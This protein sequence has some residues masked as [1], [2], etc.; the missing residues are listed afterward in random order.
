MTRNKFVVVIAT[1][2]LVVI[3]ACILTGSPAVVSES[4]Q[5]S[6]AAIQTEIAGIVASTEAAQTSLA[7][8]VLATLGSIVTDTP[9]FTFTPSLTFTPSPS[10]TLTI[11]Q[12][13]SVPMVSVS[14]ET[15]C[16]SG[17][18]DPYAILGTLPAGVK[19]EVVARTDY[20]DWIIKL[21]SNPAITCWLWGQYATIT[22]DTTT[23]PKVTPV[24]SPTPAASFQVEYEYTCNSGVG[25]AV[26]FRVTNNGSVTW[27]SNRVSATDQVTAATF[28]DN[29][30]E[31]PHASATCGIISLDQNLEAGEVG[32]TGVGPFTNPVG[33]SFTATIRVCSQDG[34][35]GVCLEKTINFTP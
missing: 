6:T 21:P 13:L 14:Q 2:G 28:T 31:F 18:G 12:T 22:G 19:A 23:L 16:R 17:P 25:Y 26:M 3:S 29:Y 8:A 7:N 32:Y 4:T 24:P 10:P 15:N 27:E 35:A 11:T 34:L 20:N 5:D 9:E 33:H 1:A 30:D